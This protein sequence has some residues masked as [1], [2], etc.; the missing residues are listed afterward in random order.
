MNCISMNDMSE[1]IAEIRQIAR[2]AVPDY[3]DRARI[4]RKNDQ[5]NDHE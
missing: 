3:I 1:M 4:L 5:A 2:E